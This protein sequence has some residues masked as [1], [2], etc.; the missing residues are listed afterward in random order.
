[1]DDLKLYGRNSD[2][3]DGILPELTI[4][5]LFQEGIRPEFQIELERDQSSTLSEA[6]RSAE[7]TESIWKRDREQSMA[8]DNNDCFVHHHSKSQYAQLQRSLPM[9]HL[10]QTESV[11]HV[12]WSV[13]PAFTTDD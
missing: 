2:Q 10:T 5:T 3:L 12:Q 4:V 7:K 1:M 9:G 11:A 8:S 13:R 6:V